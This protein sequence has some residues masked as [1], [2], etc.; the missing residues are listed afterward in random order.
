MIVVVGREAELA[1]VGNVLDQVADGPVVLLLSGEAGIGKTTVWRAGV[2]AARDRGFGA[3]ECQPAASEVRLSYSGLA[4]LLA[5]LPVES[6]DRL[7]PPQRTAL[8]AALL[9]DG[10]E[11]PSPDPRAVAVGFLSLLDDRARS[12]PVVVAIDDVQWLDSSTMRVVEYAVRRCRGPVAVLAARRD[13]SESE[14]SASAN[15]L[16]KAKVEEADGL[17]PRDPDRQHV[18]VVGPL[19]LGA[20]HQVIHEHLGRRLPR[21][22]MVRIA[23]ASAGN[24]FFALELARTLDPAAP[25]LSRLPDSL[26]GLVADRIGRLEPAVRDALLVVSA[27]AAPHVDLIAQA[28]GDTDVVALLGQAEDAGVVELRA[29]GAVRFAHPLLATSIYGD[30][31]PSVHRGLHRMLAGVVTDVEERARHLALAAVGPDPETVAALDAAATSARRRG[32][33]ATAAE[34]LELAV[35]LGADD[36]ARR[37]LAAEDH[38]RA[39]DSDRARQLLES[40]IVDLDPGPMRAGAL[41][42]LGMICFETGAVDDA[43]SRYE[44]AL[45]EADHGTARRVEVALDLAFVL[46]MSG[47]VRDSLPLVLD[48]VAQAERIGDEGLLAEALIVVVIVQF[49]LG[50]GTDDENLAR[51]LD[52]EDP[53][54]R[55]RANSWPSLLASIIFRVSHRFEEAQTTLTVARQRLLDQGADNELWKYAWQALPLACAT[56][57]LDSAHSIVDELVERA[58]MIESNQARAMARA[59]QAELWAWIGRTDEA[60]E[61]ATEAL[62]LFSGGGAQTFVLWTLTSLGMAAMSVGDYQAAADH[63]GPAAAALTAMGLGEPAAFP[64][65][66]DAAEALIACGRPD[67]AEPIIELL[68]ASGRRP[69]RM[70][71]QAVGARCRALLHAASGDPEAAQAA[72][73]HALA[74]HDRLPQLRYDRA[75]TLLVHGQHQRRRRQ[76]RKARASLEEA[77]RLFEQVGCAQWASRARAEIEQLGLKPTDSDQLTATEQ[78]VADLAASGMTVKEVA[79]ALIVSPKTIEAHITAIYRK[80]GIHSRAELARWTSANGNG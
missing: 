46:F 24:P 33:A 41:A 61:A 71:A 70:W 34:L 51:A 56:G 64:F 77:A 26:R 52:L 23:E 75:R 79:A 68:E 25:Q 7:P 21:P 57:D 66:P 55:S 42:L 10:G 18:V 50:E 4:D 40:A 9:R 30:T 2:D 3:W 5:D 59:L 35:G 44:Q 73:E 76:R 32:A 29:D 43:V 22:A 17:R 80:L 47:R 48:A 54:R 28:L 63:L 13:P 62:A 12:G 72:F 20:L 16:P 60:R 74:A 69:D 37:V 58:Q 1:A 27:L 39:G 78:R 8:S 49:M 19:S 36:A 65:L 67:E 31:V 45:A 38:A 53:E 14:L 11:D 15:G 6:L